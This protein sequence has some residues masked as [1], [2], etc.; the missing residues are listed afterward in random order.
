MLSRGALRLDFSLVQVFF[1]RFVD[2]MLM[3]PFL[4]LINLLPPA[5]EDWGKVIF[6]LMSVC[7]WG[8]LCLCLGGSLSGEG[9]SLSRGSLSR[10]TSHYGKERAV[11][12][13]L[14]YIP[15]NFVE[16]VSGSQSHLIGL[17]SLFGSKF[18]EF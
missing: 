13:L 6:S 10:E 3:F 9:G 17:K 15:I 4:P 18:W 2:Q 16:F 1:L 5:N 12:I 8:S 14:E 11:R 7:P